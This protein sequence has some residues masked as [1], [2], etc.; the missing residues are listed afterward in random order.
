MSSLE[1]NVFSDLVEY[2]RIRG[3]RVV[4][5]IDVPSHVYAGWTAFPSEY[6]KI[7]ICEEGDPFNGHLNPD[8][9]NVL[10][11]LKSIYKDLLELGTSSEYFHI[12][13]DE[14]NTACLSHSKSMKNFDY[15]VMYLWASFV[16]NITTALKSANNNTTPK[17]VVIWS[18]DLTDSYIGKLNFIQNLVVQFWLGEISSILEQGVKVVFS[19]VGHWYLDCGYGPWKPAMTHAT[20]EPYTTWQKFYEYRPWTE[21]P[22]NLKQILGGEACLWSETV[23]PESVEVRLWPRVAAMAERLWSDPDDFDLA[24][25]FSRISS[26]RERLVAKNI[27]SDAIWPEWCW[28]NPRLCT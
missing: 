28:R 2:A 11:L 24:E 5:E 9:P 17:N 21:Y 3:V 27:N 15:N 14:V 26:H 18:S 13:A 10:E 1:Q 20:C 22:R 8:N 19:T 23:V 4:L 7:I 6:G 12:G 16:N 25:V